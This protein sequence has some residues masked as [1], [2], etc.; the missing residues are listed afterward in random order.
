MP[1]MRGVPIMQPQQVD[2]VVVAVRRPHDGVDV[3]LRRLG[4]GQKHTGVMVELDKDHR[5]LNAIIERA[6][7]GKIADPAKMRIVKVPLDFG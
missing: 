3:K 1:M 4:I 5:T 6:G 2:A 7:F